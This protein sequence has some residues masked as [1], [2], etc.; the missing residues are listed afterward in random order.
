[1]IGFGGSNVK[2]VEDLDIFKL[3]HQLAL[4]VYS[5]TKAFPKEI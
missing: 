2:S 5:V 4:K 3:A 1:M